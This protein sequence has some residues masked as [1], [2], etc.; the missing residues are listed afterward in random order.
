MAVV[1]SASRVV[2]AAVVVAT[3]GVMAVVT[4]VPMASIA[5]KEWP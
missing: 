3:A 2:A 1:S 5:A 4:A